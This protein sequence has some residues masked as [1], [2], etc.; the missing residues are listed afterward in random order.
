[1][2]YIIATLILVLSF[3]VM[4]DFFPEKKKDEKSKTDQ[5]YEEYTKMLQERI[6][7]SKGVSEACI[8][9]IKKYQDLAKK[10]SD[11]PSAKR[12]ALE[13]LKFDHIKNELRSLEDYCLTTDTTK[14]EKKDEKD[15][16]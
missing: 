5:L 6:K 9:N 4:A 13:N 11:I 15:D 12:S 2:R 3:T 16:T 14:E 10:Y 1:M 7:N 8:T